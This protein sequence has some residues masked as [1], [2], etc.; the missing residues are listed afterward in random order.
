M[1]K[2]WIKREQAHIRKMIKND[3]KIARK[4]KS[5]YLKAMDDIQGQID[6]FYGRY[7]SKEGITMEE[8]RRRV[9]KA[10]I[11]KYRSKAKRYVNNKTFTKRANEE[12]RLYNVTMRTNRLELLKS[13]VHLE[14][15]AMTSEEQRILLEEMFKS[16]RNEFE[17]QSGILGQSLRYNER[18]I[19]S[20]VNSSF[21]NATWSDRLWGN[22]NALR[23]ELDKLLNRGIIQGL[24]PR[25]LAREL[26]KTFDSGVY[27]SERL[28]R[29]EMARVQG[30]VQADSYIQAGVDSYEFIASIDEKTSEICLDTDGKI[31]KL[32]DRVVGVNFP[33]LHPNCRSST[34]P[35]VDRES[36]DKGLKSRGM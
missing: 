16:A 7:A 6:A 26:R 17:R 11:N 15:L 31:F 24:N 21:L 14:L 23:A 10:D 28:L 1:S 20:I 30:D 27:N 25:E 9:A 3:T 19:A 13:N 22:Q 12:M 35:V 18:D 36:W 2:Y 4:L 32:T 8:A 33:P 34:S 29:T 5:N